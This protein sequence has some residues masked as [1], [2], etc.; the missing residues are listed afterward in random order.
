[1]SLPKV[2]LALRPGA[3][4]SI[5]SGVIEWLDQVQSQPTQ[6]EIDAYIAANPE[7]TRA[8]DEQARLQAMGN[9]MIRF[10][11]THTPAEIAARVNA[12]VTT[13]AAARS[14]LVHLSIAVS[15]LA[16]RELR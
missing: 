3:S 11:V 8:E 5:R 2:L 7:P 6:A 9:P 12:D 14:L 15:A 4:F 16:R 10:L 13:L 1:M